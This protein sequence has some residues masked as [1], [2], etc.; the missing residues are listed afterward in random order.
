[1]EIS[2]RGRTNGETLVT[3]R[4]ACYFTGVINIFPKRTDSVTRT[5]RDFALSSPLSTLPSFAAGFFYSDVAK[6]FKRDGNI[7]DRRGKPGKKEKNVEEEGKSLRETAVPFDANRAA[8]LWPVAVKDPVSFSI[9][10]PRELFVG[11]ERG[12]TI[13]IEPPINQRLAGKR[14]K[15]E[16]TGRK[17]KKLITG[18][19]SRKQ[20][21]S[22][23]I[24]I[25]VIK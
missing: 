11:L 19:I 7:F 12:F 15:G 14:T 8:S 25:M 18:L 22:V 16:S 24:K 20:G 9:S 2:R 21:A 13:I 17:W 10:H 1:M 23:G 6:V 3:A 4:T 5:N